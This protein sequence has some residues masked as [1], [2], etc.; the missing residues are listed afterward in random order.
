VA[1]IST[2]LKDP[3]AVLDYEFNWSEW[4]GPS[5]IID[6][7]DVIASPGITVNSSFSS[8]TTVTVWL[9]GGTAGQP[10][11]VTNR[12]TTNQGR[13]DDRTMTIRVAER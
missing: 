2:F 9:S 1:A 4:L 6:T 5:E 3:D 8:P 10:Y 11:T 13:T 7:F 12:I